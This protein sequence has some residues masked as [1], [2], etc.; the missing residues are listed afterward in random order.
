MGSFDISVVVAQSGY[1][2]TKTII[3]DLSLP[4]FRWDTRW[5]ATRRTKKPLTGPW[6]QSLP[7]DPYPEFWRARVVWVAKWGDDYQ[8]PVESTPEYWARKARVSL[9]WSFAHVVLL[10]SGLIWMSDA[11]WAGVPVS[12]FFI[13]LHGAKWR[14]QITR[15]RECSARQVLED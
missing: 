5:I 13:L 15:V 4:S 12:L 9:L 7:S 8:N 3:L 2:C 11:M 14:S 10:M 6:L 1:S